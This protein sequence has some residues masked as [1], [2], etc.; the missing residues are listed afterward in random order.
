[1][2]KSDSSG[3][4]CTPENWQKDAWHRDFLDILIQ[5]MSYAANLTNLMIKYD[6][7]CSGV[8]AVTDL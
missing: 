8:R 5:E 7:S 1:M 6:S 3:N 2:L 4:I